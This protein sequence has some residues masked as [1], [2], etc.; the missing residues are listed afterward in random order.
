MV[1]QEVW[2]VLDMRLKLMDEPRF[3]NARKAG[4]QDDLSIAFFAL[5]PSV[6]QHA[7]FG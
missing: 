2:L 3:P 1:Q 7:H 6:E 4:K 5:L